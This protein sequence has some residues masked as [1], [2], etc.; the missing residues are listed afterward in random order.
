MVS[1]SKRRYKC[2]KNF[3]YIFQTIN[4]VRSL[5][6]SHDKVGTK[7]ANLDYLRYFTLLGIEKVKRPISLETTPCELIFTRSGSL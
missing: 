3:Y 5:N 6:K 4:S 2:K 1:I 7:N